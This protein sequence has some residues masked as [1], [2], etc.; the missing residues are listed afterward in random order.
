MSRNTSE[1]QWQTS[2]IAFAVAAQKRDVSKR[3]IPVLIDKKAEVPFFLKNLLYS[4]LSDA[5]AYRRNFPQ[6]V[7]AILRKPD[8]SLNAE[9]I[10][11]LQIESLRAQQALLREKEVAFTR[12]KATRMTSVLVALVSMIAASLTLLTGLFG[13]VKLGHRTIDFLIGAAAG[14]LASIIA[15]LVTR[16]LRKKTPR[17][18]GVNGEQ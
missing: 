15:V 11:R 12:S 3:I 13:S 4:D 7:R 18:E 8:D 6:L 14:I 9:Q 17:S 10:Q 5:D 2:E 1:S 16:V